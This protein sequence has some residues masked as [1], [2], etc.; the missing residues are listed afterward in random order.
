MLWT[1]AVHKH[2]CSLSNHGAS[3]IRKQLREPWPYRKKWWQEKEWVI[4]LV[5][6]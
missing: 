1:V 3:R 6:V 4:T 2:V 5:K